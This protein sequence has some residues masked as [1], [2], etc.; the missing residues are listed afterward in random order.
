MGLVDEPMGRGEKVDIDVDA[1]RASA[2]RTI[3]EAAELLGAA[4]ENQRGAAYVHL[5]LAQ[6]AALF[7][8]A[9]LGRCGTHGAELLFEGRSDGL[10][11]SC[12]QGCSW[13]LS[14]Q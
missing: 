2:M 11:V 3:S 9:S 13:K 8:A 10:Y 4:D 14:T 12:G 1:V 7:P 5:Q 6:A